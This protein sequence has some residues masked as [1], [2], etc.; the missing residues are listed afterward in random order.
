MV[1]LHSSN[2]LRFSI[3]PP[4]AL[5]TS[6]DYHLLVLVCLLP[7]LS[8]MAWR[9]N[10]HCGYLTASEGSWIQHKIKLSRLC[11]DRCCMK[12]FN[13]PLDEVEKHYGSAFSQSQSPV[14]L[15]RRFFS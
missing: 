4:I 1:P 5:A 13:A 2:F 11:S 14:F 10:G 6:Y 7:Y 15:F 9:L 8:M 3:L 12:A